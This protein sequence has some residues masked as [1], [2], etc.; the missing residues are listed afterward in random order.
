MILDLLPSDF[1]ESLRSG[2][3]QIV[4][5]NAISPVHS[6][7]SQ[8]QPPVQLTPFGSAWMK[9][10]SYPAKVHQKMKLHISGT[11]RTKQECRWRPSIYQKQSSASDSDLLRK[12]QSDSNILSP[13]SSNPKMPVRRVSP[14]KKIHTVESESMKNATWDEI[15]API[16][17]SSLLDRFH[18][19]MIPSGLQ[20]CRSSFAHTVQ[21]PPIFPRREAQNSSSLASVSSPCLR[22]LIPK[23]SELDKNGGDSKSILDT[24]DSPESTRKSS[25]KT[26]LDDTS[27][28]TSPE[29]PRTSSLY[30]K[31]DHLA[32]PYN[33]RTD[34]AS[35]KPEYLADTNTVTSPFATTSSPMPRLT[36]NPSSLKE[37]RWTT[38]MVRHASL[39]KPR[40]QIR[41]INSIERNMNSIEEDNLADIVNAQQST[42]RMECNGTKNSGR[43]CFLKHNDSLT[44]LHAAL[45]PTTEFKN[46]IQASGCHIQIG[47]KAA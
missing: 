37:D 12:C 44:Q 45:S 14:K 46:E 24:K 2:R 15:K 30:R 9:M 7:S 28:G 23:G 5:D 17:P 21:V 6:W 16:K 34:S 47:P 20:S 13:H 31:Q 33:K 19:T 11:R 38:E 18:P 8:V 41:R 43:T 10:G 4:A 25:F 29:N 32:T 35:S 36:S 27:S 3:I 1:S 40:G 22:S 26:L 42:E 39:A